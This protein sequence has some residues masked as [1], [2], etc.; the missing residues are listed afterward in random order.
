M[1][2]YCVKEKKLP[3]LKYQ[4]T[5]VIKKHL[6]D[7]FAEL[8]PNNLFQEGSTRPGGGGVRRRPSRTEGPGAT[9]TFNELGSGVLLAPGGP[10]FDYLPIYIVIHLYLH[11]Y[12]LRTAENEGWEAGYPHPG[13]SPIFYSKL[14][15]IAVVFPLPDK[16]RG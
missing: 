16:T 8:V 5:T 12:L 9:C 11:I 6:Y 15:V 4:K 14:F 3:N 1:V 13:V 7:A 2:L 10:T